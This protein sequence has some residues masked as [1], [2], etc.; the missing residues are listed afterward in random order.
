MKDLKRN[1]R[2]WAGQLISWIKEAIDKKQTSFQDATNDTGV[3]MAS[4]RTKFPDILLFTDKSSGIIFNGWELKFPDTRVDDPVL[5]ENALEKA[6]KIESDSFVTWNGAEAMIWEIKNKVYSID[7]L[8]VL[9]R[10]PRIPTINVREDLADPS[11]YAYHEPILKE[12]AYEII[13]DLEIFHQNGVLKEAID[14][15]GNITDSIKKAQNVIV[16]QFTVS[17]SDAIGCDRTFR[18]KFNQWK[19]Y[20]SSTLKI[21][22]SSSR[23]ITALDPKQV[24][25]TFTFYNVIGKVLFYLTLS[26]NL[27]AELPRLHITSYKNLQKELE[28]YFTR[29]KAIDYQ[30]IFMPYFTDTLNYSKIVCKT[31]FQLIGVLTEFDFKILPSDVIGTILENLV[32]VDEKQKLG[33]YFTPEYLANFVA[34]PVVADRNSLLLDPTSGTGTLLNSFYNILNYFGNKSHPRLLN[35]IWGIDISHFPAI[36]SVINLYRRDLTN[37][38][39]FPK[40]IRD[41]FFNLYI[42]KKISFP[43][44]SDH[45]KHCWVEIP[46]Y[47]GIASNFPFIQ[48][49]DIPNNTLTSYFKEKFEISQPAFLRNGEFY[50]NERAD[51]F[52]YCIY[53]SLSFLKDGGV[54]SAITSNAW[55]GKEYGFQFKRFLL[56]NFHIKYVVR[57]TAEH[58]FK[59]SQVSTI[60]FVVEKCNYSEPTKFININIKL[61]DFFNEDDY[62]SSQ[63]SQIETLYSHIDNCDPQVNSYWIKDKVYNERLK[64]Q[65]GFLDMVIIDR[66]TLDDS[67]SEGINWDQF[68]IAR[69]P[70]G[71]FDKFL[72]KYHPGIFKVIRGER[73]GWNQMFVISNKNIAST[74][75]APQYLI[76]Y[77]KS[78][79]EFENIEFSNKYR[80]SAFVCAETL[81]SLDQG[82]KEWINRFVN[83]KNRNGS[84]TIPETCSDHKPFWYSINP[85]SAHIVT[86]INP[87]ERFFFSY[88]TS[89][90][91]IDQRL[92]AMQVQE[93][94][95]IELI[96]AL[97]N[98]IVTLLTLEFKGTSRNLGALDLN[99]NY[100]K[101]LKLLNPHIISEEHKELIL[102]K[103]KVIKNR[104]IGP[105]SEELKRRDRIEFDITVLKAYGLSEELLP[106]LYDL[107]LSSVEKRISLKHK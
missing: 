64:S 54:L 94:I 60:Y 61:S 95:D 36:L 103:F 19:I 71:I 43:D 72:I 23:K 96:A 42:G 18:N 21:L 50:I 49:E 46:K 76:P 39:N 22:E 58:W 4:G 69:N 84:M 14:I 93:G 79:D 68:F 91:I 77:V 11:K 38:D 26:E 85:K 86:A 29:A 33:Q 106:S 45:K 74:G 87:Y 78:P 80:F 98:S 28:Q 10:Y 31:L 41:D 99:A 101:N 70:L 100:L 30:A 47:D 40:I 16:P 44:P 9:K 88:S 75:I 107:L 27:P 12:R 53:H 32:P 25:A 62:I 37:T 24:L 35:Q 81:N 48:Q 92:I 105:V 20:E 17:I 52:T 8:S 66:H 59:D 13:H 57:S 55:L 6:K 67:I 90:F 63:L 73:T 34:F 3:K 56:D 51:Y 65:N 102:N 82:T 5:L 15:S 1:E 83:Q 89:P 97:L 2:D 104:I 7:S